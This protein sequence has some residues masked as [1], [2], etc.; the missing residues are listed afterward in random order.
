M[1]THI[2]SNPNILNGKAVIRGT[3]IPI[4][5]KEIHEEYPNVSLKIFEMIV[6]YE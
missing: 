2:S 3:R 4:T 6:K 5:L 1:K